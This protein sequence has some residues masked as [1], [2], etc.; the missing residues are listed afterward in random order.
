MIEWAGN[1]GMN[2]TTDRTELIQFLEHTY[3]P[4]QHYPS[5]PWAFA[6]RSDPLR[7]FVLDPQLAEAATVGQVLLIAARLDARGCWIVD[8][9]GELRNANAD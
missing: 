8:K 6:M 3:G 2:E 1:L 9:G 4:V 7:Q 5:A